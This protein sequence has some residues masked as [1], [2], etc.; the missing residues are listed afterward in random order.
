MPHTTGIE[1]SC[2]SNALVLPT[3]DIDDGSVNPSRF[4][5]C[6]KGDGFRN[7]G[8]LAKTRD[9]QSPCR[10]EKILGILNAFLCCQLLHHF[11]AA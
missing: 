2:A 1:E 5:C 8:W 9:F 6:E 11:P 4:F 10:F 3:I 7:I